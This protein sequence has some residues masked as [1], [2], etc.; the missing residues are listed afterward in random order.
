VETGK[1]DTSV[2]C[3]NFIA[4]VLGTIDGHLEM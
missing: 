2:V 3:T 4:P 1:I